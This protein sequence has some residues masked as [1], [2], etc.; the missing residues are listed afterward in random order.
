[1]SVGS[2]K[3]LLQ[4]LQ[5]SPTLQGASVVFGEENINAEDFL[6][7]MVCVVPIGGTWKAPGY[8]EF[9]DTSLN[10]IWSTSEAIEIWM[11]SAADPHSAQPPSEIDS[12]DAVEELRARVLQAL[13]FQAP[14][15]LMYSPVSGRWSRMGDGSNRYG[16][17]YALTVQVDIAI[18]DVLYPKATVRTVTESV[19]ISE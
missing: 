14:N 3:T 9:A 18:P 11:W 5:S 2:L 15:G 7:P 12:A 8:F 16:R 17:G 13:Q 19:S 1:M 4:M 10:A 6:L